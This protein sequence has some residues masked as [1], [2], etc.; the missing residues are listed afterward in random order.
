MSLLRNASKIS[1]ITLIS[2]ISGFV[3]DNLFAA[4]FGTQEEL[5]IFLLAFKVPNFLRRI[6]AEGACGQAF[7]PVLSEYLLKE[8]PEAQK[9]FL[10]TLFS[11]LSLIVTSLAVLVFCYPEVLVKVFAAGYLPGTERYAMS[12]RLMRYVFPY[13][14]FIAWAAFFAAALQTKK[15]FLLPALIPIVLNTVLIICALGIGWGYLDTIYLAWSVPLAGILQVLVIG[16]GY[17]KYYSWPKLTYRFNDKGVTKVTGLITMGSYSLAIGQVGAIIDNNILSSMQP[18]SVSW[19]YFTERLCYLPL[20]VFGISIITVLGPALAESYQSGNNKKFVKQLDWALLSAGFLGIPSALG[21]IIFAEPIIMTL[22]GHGKFNTH[23]VIMTA[24]S[25]RIMALGVPAFM[26]VKVLASAFYTQQDTKTPAW[27]ATVGLV[28]NLTLAIG[29][30][31]SLQH[32]STAV[33]ITIQHY[34]VMYMLQKK[35]HRA[36]MYTI[37]RTVYKNLVKTLVASSA[38]LATCAI[39]PS[40]HVWSEMALLSQMLTLTG[41]LCVAG[42]CFAVVLYSLSWKPSLVTEVS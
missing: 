16:L 9:R 20:G 1:I 39:I 37:S 28:C 40:V 7:I 23:D 38:M 36:G 12:I 27:C 18:G 29:L 6:F 41:M 19:M 21:L 42:G 2:R 4:T 15:Q 22:F 24:S 25:L 8:S 26:W 35:L 30:M 17:R 11:L 10:D 32:V 31:Q 3:R 5:D 33:A 34:V 14:A 13:I